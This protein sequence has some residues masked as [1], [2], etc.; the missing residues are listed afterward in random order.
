[1]E[2]L[3][4]RYRHQLNRISW[5]SNH[6]HSTADT[7]CPVHHRL[8]ILILS[9]GFYRATLDAHA[10]GNTCVWSN[11]GAVVRSLR[12]FLQTK[13]RGPKENTAAITAAVT[14]ADELRSLGSHG[15]S[16]ERQVYVPHLIKFAKEL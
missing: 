14:G 12:R 10:A 8:A 6:A 15:E 5:A 1:M 2:P 13:V 16:I 3:L 11:D 9:Y 4:I 7:L